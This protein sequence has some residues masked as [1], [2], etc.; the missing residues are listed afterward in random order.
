MPTFPLLGC[1]TVP[2]VTNSCCWGRATPSYTAGD[3][4]APGGGGVC[5]CGR[6]HLLS[7]AWGVQGIALLHVSGTPHFEQV[8]T[9]A[10]APHTRC[11][12]HGLISHV[13]QLPPS[14]PSPVASS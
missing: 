14:P 9:A 3:S 8:A 13:C 4:G 6:R 10:H 2:L 11:A 12:S 5:V 7:C 1:L